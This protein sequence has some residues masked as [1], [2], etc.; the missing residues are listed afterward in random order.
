[1]VKLLIFKLFIAAAY[2][3]DPPGMTRIHV[4]VMNIAIRS[5]TLLAASFFT[6]VRPLIFYLSFFLGQFQKP[7]SNKKATYSKDF[8]QK[9]D[10]LSIIIDSFPRNIYDNY[11]SYTDV[12]VNSYYAIFTNCFVKFFGVRQL[13]LDMA[14]NGLMFKERGEICMNPANKD[15]FQ[16][17]EVT[18]QLGVTRRMLLNYE[19]LGL[20]TPAYKSE[21]SGF[22]YYSA[23]NIVHIRIIKTLQGLG[24]SLSEISRYFGNTEKLED[25]IERMTSLRSQLDL[26]IVQL[27]L[28]QSQT[29]GS[30]ILHITLPSFT[31]FCREFKGSD[32]A[33]KTDG[34]RQTF[35]EATKKYKLNS[36]GKM[37]TEVSI[38]RASDGRYLVPVAVDPGISDEHVKTLPQINAICIYYR[39]PYENFHTVQDKLLDYAKE[40][41]LTTCGYFRN[42]FMEGPPTHGANKDAYITQIALPVQFLT[43]G[44][45]I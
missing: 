19:D 41:N 45:S 3:V 20:L 12:R 39:G 9:N 30:E 44:S 35:I 34:L 27:Q 11:N 40:N 14:F 21:S 13:P 23:D 26:C 7:P 36:V 8:A 17:G 4:R 28:R 2:A 25:V 1:M 31:A 5:A 32:L 43:T 18:K 15:L 42:T 37:C 29:A 10:Y 33:E 22:R 16:I 24:L 6:A 38:G